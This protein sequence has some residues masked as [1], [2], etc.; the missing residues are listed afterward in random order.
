VDLTVPC[1]G[2]FCL[3]ATKY[4]EALDGGDL[5]LCFL[6]SGTIFHEA[7]DGGLQVA[8]IPWEKETTYRLPVATWRELMETYYPNCAWLLLRRDVFEGLARYKN[9]Q[10]LITW[11]Q[12]MERLL[13]AAE[14]PAT[15]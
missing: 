9:R 15:P 6:F 1:S 13:A 2:D 14:E 8:Q 7:D 4:F 5:P 3:A 11:E 10:G 12:A